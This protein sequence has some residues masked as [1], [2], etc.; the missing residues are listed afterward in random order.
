MLLPDFDL[1]KNGAEIIREKWIKKNLGL[2]VVLKLGALGS[3][4]INDRLQILVPPITS[5]NPMI[6]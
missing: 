2:S 4:F 1:K 6:I 5:F 3:M